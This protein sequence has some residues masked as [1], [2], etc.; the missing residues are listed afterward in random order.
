MFGWTRSLCHQKKSGSREDKVGGA[1]RA[2][3]VEPEV[4]DSTGMKPKAHGKGKPHFIDTYL[5]LPGLVIRYS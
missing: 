2:K 5:Y 3:L 1:D 4:D